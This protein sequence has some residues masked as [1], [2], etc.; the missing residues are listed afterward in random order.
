MTPR[1]VKRRSGSR[2]AGSSVRRS[3][4]SYRNAGYLASTSSLPRD[5]RP[6]RPTSAHSSYSNF[7]AA[8]PSSYHVPDMTHEPYEPAPPQ[9]ES[10]PALTNYDGRGYDVAGPYNDPPRGYETA[11]YENRR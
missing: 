10:V 2:G 6:S 9:T 7:H 8:R 4:R 1:R 3:R 11:H 5:P